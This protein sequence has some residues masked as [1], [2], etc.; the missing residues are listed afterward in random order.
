MKV[1]ILAKQFLKNPKTITPNLILFSQYAVNSLQ[2]SQISSNLIEFFSLDQFNQPQY[3]L[4]N[5]YT[6]SKFEQ[7]FLTYFSKGVFQETV[8]GTS[9][10]LVSSFKAFNLSIF[11]AAKLTTIF[12]LEHKRAKDALSPLPTPTINTDSVIKILLFINYIFS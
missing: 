10:A 12:F 11:L 4:N 8:A 3:N 9:F 1:L 6:I 5:P 2:A 7:L